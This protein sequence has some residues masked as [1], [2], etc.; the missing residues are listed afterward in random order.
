MPAVDAGFHE[1][2]QQHKVAGLLLQVLDGLFPRGNG[3]DPVAQQAQHPRGNV[4]LLGF[5]VHHQDRLPLAGKIRQF[6]GLGRGS[7]LLPCD[8]KV[9][10]EAGAPFVAVD[11]DPAVV[12]PD[13]VPD[14]GKPEAGAALAHDFLGIEGFEDALPV[15]AGKAGSRIGH[16]ENRVLP[17]VDLVA[18]KGGL[19]DILVAGGDHHLPR[20]LDGFKGVHYEV[21]DAFLDM[22]RRAGDVQQV[23]RRPED[24]LHP[25]MLKP[26]FSV[27]RGCEVL[28]DHIVEA[29]RLTG[30][31]NPPCNGEKIGHHGGGP[32]AR[33]LN[34]QEGFFQL[35]LPGKLEDNELRVVDDSRE[36]VV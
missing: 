28:F 32:F 18:G 7:E 34:G 13:R 17:P 25:R 8:G 6:H 3:K 12:V 33:F 14:H 4:P 19:L 1:H 5:V 9:E 31:G 15:L 10:F 11:G 27:F 20:A 29:G 2:V 30:A 16:G 35:A 24:A 36:D 22:D 23:R 26:E 21:H